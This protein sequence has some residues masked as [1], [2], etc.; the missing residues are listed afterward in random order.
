MKYR[1]IKG[2]KRNIDISMKVIKDTI[3]ENCDF[4]ENLRRKP[5]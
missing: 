1:Y 3:F 2:N 5:H 4:L